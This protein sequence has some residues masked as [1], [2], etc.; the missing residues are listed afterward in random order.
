MKTKLTLAGI[1]V[2][3]DD[4]IDSHLWCMAPSLALT[5]SFWVSAFVFYEIKNVEHDDELR[6]S[7]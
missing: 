1:F 5:H 4:F 2:E 6:T 7:T 3:L